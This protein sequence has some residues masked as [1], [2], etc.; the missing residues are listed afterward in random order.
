M[1]LMTPSRV[2]CD[3]EVETGQSR[4][5]W[6]S[7]RRSGAMEICQ[8]TDQRVPAS[9]LRR[10]CWLWPFALV[11]VVLSAG[12]A[13]AHGFPASSVRICVFDDNEECHE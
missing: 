6:R 11:T 9:L 8:R 13:S 5:R 1:S 12:A 10:G 7:K 2:R 3:D 4:S